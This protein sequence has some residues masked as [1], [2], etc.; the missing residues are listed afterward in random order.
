MGLSGKRTRGP[1]KQTPWSRNADDGMSI[2]RLAL[3]TSDPRQRTRLEAMFETGYQVRRALQRGA[4]DAC[5]AYWAA[6]HER[7]R[8]PSAVRDRLGLSR[9]ALEHRAYAHLDGAPQLRRFVT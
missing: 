6:T 3:D 7:A 5:R 8:S 4:R 9:P 2:L 1:N